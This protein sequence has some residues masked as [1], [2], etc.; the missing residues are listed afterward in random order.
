VVFTGRVPQI[1]AFADRFTT[2]ELTFTRGHADQLD[3]RQLNAQQLCVED[4]CVT[5]DQFLKIVEQSGQSPAAAPPPLK[6]QPR[7]DM[8]LSPIDQPT[9]ENMETSNIPEL[10]D[11]PPIVPDEP[12]QEVVPADEPSVELPYLLSSR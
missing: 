5:R 8:P 12:E 1:G 7:N 4:V 2:R 9:T 3:V 11:A 6:E 10:S